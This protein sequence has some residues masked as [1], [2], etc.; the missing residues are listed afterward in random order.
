MAIVESLTAHGIVDSTAH[1][2]LNV[3]LAIYG[4]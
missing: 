3:F 4:K 2:D 1:I